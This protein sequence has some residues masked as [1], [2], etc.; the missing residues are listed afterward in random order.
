MDTNHRQAHHEEGGFTLIEVLVVIL[1][2][3]ILAAIALPAFLGQRA[4]SY[5]ARAKTNARNMASQ[6]E[7]CWHVN[8]DGYVGCAAALTTNNT[9]LAIGGGPDEVRIV[10]ETQL[11][12]EIEATS[13]SDS[14]GGNHSFRIVHNIGGVF[15]RQCTPAGEGGCR[16][17]GTW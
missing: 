17:D 11:G 13:K 8:G 15:D 10:K 14:G 6:I 4:K 12:Y 9:G 7:A 1:I 5:D 2:I 16:G 3:G